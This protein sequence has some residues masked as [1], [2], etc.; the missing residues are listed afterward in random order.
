MNKS[1]F[2][3]NNQRGFIRLGTVVFIV[4]IFIILRVYW[5]IDVIELIKYLIEKGV[6]LF[7][8]IYAEMKDAFF[9][10]REKVT[11]YL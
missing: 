4:L 10:I 7:K 9:I 6:E 5:D 8:I 2:K 3:K 1:H 11:E